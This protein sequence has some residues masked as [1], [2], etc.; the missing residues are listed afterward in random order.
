M[1]FDFIY[2]GEWGYV[3]VEVLV[4]VVVVVVLGVDGEVVCL[5]FYV[6]CWEEWG[7]VF[8]FFFDV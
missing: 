1:R 6:V 5:C 3:L 7:G 2:C 4:K 8:G